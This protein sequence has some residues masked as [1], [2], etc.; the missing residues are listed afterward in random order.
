M[1]KKKPKRRK[2]SKDTRPKPAVVS[3][4]AAEDLC[5]DIDAY[6]EELKVELPGGNWTRSSAAM[7]AVALF[8]RSR[9]KS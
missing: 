9:N 1:A 6:A 3:F 2:K 8:L 7:N 4:R 5:K